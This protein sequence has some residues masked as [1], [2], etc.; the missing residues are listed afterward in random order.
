MIV[1]LLDTQT[2]KTH[3][4][5]NDYDAYWWAD[6]NGSCDCN[7]ALQMGVSL[8]E[9]NDNLCIGSKRF[10]IIDSDDKAYSLAELNDNYPS[11]LLSKHLPK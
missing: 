2:G 7:R 3:V 1:T 6:G 8:P 10:L 9:S 4:T 11:E 5:G